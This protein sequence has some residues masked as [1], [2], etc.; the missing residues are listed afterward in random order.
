MLF[1]LFIPQSVPRLCVSLVLAKYINLHCRDNCGFYSSLDNKHEY[2][3][4]KKKKAVANKLRIDGDGFRV[5]DA[6][7]DK[8]KR[9]NA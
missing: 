8:D 2:A 7:K 5:L 4:K 3:V 6:I 9:L 1:L